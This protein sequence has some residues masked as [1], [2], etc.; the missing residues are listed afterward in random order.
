MSGRPIVAGSVNESTVVRIIDSTT[1]LPEEGVTSATAG[2]NL[3]YRRE[4]AALVNLTESDLTLLTDAHSDGGML[5]IDDGYYRVDVPDAAF[6]SGVGGVQIGGTAT[7]M[8]VV[9]TYHPIWTALPTT[10]RGTDN[11]ALAANYTAARAANL[12]NLDATISTRATPAQVASA[13]TDI[14]LD[15]LLAAD[16]DPAAKPGVAT[17]LLNELIENDGGVSRFTT[18]ALEQALARQIE[19]QGTV[20]AQQALSIMLAVLAGVTDT[21]GVVFRT[22]DGVSIRVSATVNASQ[23]RTAIT[24]T[25]SS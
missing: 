14:H 11:A 20:T 18:N 9:G 16:Y 5:H 4:G 12:D 6:A 7:G 21:G 19:A 13:L 22:A 15:H 17:A 8:V 23:E 2:L 10:M 1:G 3:W 25:P 24:L